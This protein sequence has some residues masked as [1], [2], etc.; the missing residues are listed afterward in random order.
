MAENLQAVA[1][2][3]DALRAENENLR[4]QLSAAGAAQP[5]TAAPVQHQFVL[6][7]GHRQELATTGVAN[8]NGRLMTAAQVRAEL[9]EGQKKVEIP[10]V[11]PTVQ[12]PPTREKSA[13]PGVDFVY[14]S[15][16][17]GLIDPKVAGTPGIN[18][19]SAPTKG[20]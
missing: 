15:V 4:G 20:K 2:E 12:V 8:I 18:G 3:R 1:A 9:G 16:A 5:G 14:P 6:S 7:E 19:P 13:V 10:D 17:P 11:K